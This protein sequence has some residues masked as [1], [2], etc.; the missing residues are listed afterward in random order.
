[1]KTQK[2]VQAN[3][4]VELVSVIVAE[5][6]ALIVEH[7]GDNKIVLGLLSK[8]HGKTVA[9]L[10]AKLASLKVYKS[11]DNAEES[12][13]PIV[14]DKIA[15][16]EDIVADIASIVGTELAGLEA[17]TKATLQKLL[18]FLLKVN[19][20][21]SEKEE[22]IN[23]LIAEMLEDDTDDTDDTDGINA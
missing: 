11:A 19:K 5:Y 14:G 20:L 1:M 9:S 18:T 21:L 6:N 15:K 10:R 4:T 16:K 7:K 12:T 17:A 3:Y 22:K 2:T 13:A 23:A 8:K